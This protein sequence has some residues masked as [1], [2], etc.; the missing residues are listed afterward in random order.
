LISPD[1]VTGA[2]GEHRT[3]GSASALGDILPLTR[4]TQTNK[5]RVVYEVTV[6]E[7]ET[8]R[9]LLRQATIEDLN[10]WARLTFSDP[11]V[12]RYMPK[13]DMTPRERAERAYN[14]YNRNWSRHGYGGWLVTDKADGQ[15][16]GDCTFD[17]EETD[18]VELGYS[19]AKAYWGKGI[20]TEAARAAVRFGFENAKLSRIVAVVVPENTASWRVLEKIGFVY[21]KQAH[22]YGVDVV[23]YAITSEQFQPGDAFYRVHAHWLSE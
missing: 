2:Y 4:P 1:Y 8:T 5:E 6:P 18:E 10:E 15:L 12:V 19:F 23:Y 22:F 14:M 21:E 20:A 16:L 9:L 11:E 3:V 13:R 17:A 7:I